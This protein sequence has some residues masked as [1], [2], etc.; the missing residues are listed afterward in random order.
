MTDFKTA[1]KFLYKYLR[2]VSGAGAPADDRDMDINGSVTS[3]VYEYTVVDDHIDV[4]RINFP[5]LDGSV[6]PGD[7]GGITG[8]L[9]TGC[10]FEVIDTDG[11]T[12]LLDFNDGDPIKQNIDFNALAGVDAQPV[13]YSGDDLLSVRFSVFKAGANLRLKKSQIIRWTIQ[14]DLSGLTLF[15]IEIQGLIAR[16]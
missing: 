15:R 12:V 13:L 10:K 11:T 8:A 2:Y 7:F 1:D 14:D 3:A 9:T 5:I 4:A 16:V 6:N